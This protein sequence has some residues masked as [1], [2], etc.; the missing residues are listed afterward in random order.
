MNHLCD[1]PLT[2]HTQELSSLHCVYHPLATFQ[3][4]QQHEGQRLKVVLHVLSE[5][6]VSSVCIWMMNTLVLFTVCEVCA[7]RCT[8]SLWPTPITHWFTPRRNA[9]GQL[10]SA[11]HRET[12][13]CLLQSTCPQTWIFMRKYQQT[14]DTNYNIVPTKQA[15][16]PFPPA[17]LILEIFCLSSLEPG[18][19]LPL[20]TINI[21]EQVNRP[22]KLFIIIVCRPFYGCTV[23]Q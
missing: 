23:I 13:W 16:L 21:Y 19:I 14:E 4:G 1:W 20:L 15:Q 3:C 18:S 11:G 2:T 17:I 10:S 12:F 5:F 7:Y 22:R 6:L 8:P 9:A